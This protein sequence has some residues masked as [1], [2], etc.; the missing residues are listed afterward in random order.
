[1]EYIGAEIKNKGID[2]VSERDVD[3]MGIFCCCLWAFRAL[4]L[5]EWLSTCA[6]V[7]SLRNVLDSQCWFS[8]GL[9]TMIRNRSGKILS[10]R[11]ISGLRRWVLVGVRMWLALGCLCA[12]ISYLHTLA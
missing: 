1:M 10:S 7:K 11:L 9:R 12:K 3:L 5:N 6:M 4:S 8:F 2:A